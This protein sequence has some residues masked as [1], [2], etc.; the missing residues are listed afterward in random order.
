MPVWGSLRKF[1]AISTWMVTTLEIIHQGITMKRWKNK[2]SESKQRVTKDH[3]EHLLSHAPYAGVFVLVSEIRGAQ[4]VQPDRWQQHLD[5]HENQHGILHA[6]FD[7]MMTTVAFAAVLVQTFQQFHGIQDVQHYL[8][9]IPSEEYKVVRQCFRRRSV[10]E[11][12]VSLAHSWD[13]GPWAQASRALT[14]HNSL[15]F[16]HSDYPVLTV[17]NLTFANRILEG[18]CESGPLLLEC[19]SVTVRDSKKWKRDSTPQFFKLVIFPI[20]QSSIG[21]NWK[22]NQE[23][24]LRGLADANF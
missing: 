21:I 7:L 14:C 22:S 3:A 10:W 17:R 15:R 13:T 8:S 24:F 2:H 19:A 11:F 4:L 1:F 20:Y 18:E 16:S 9:N 12:A 5:G 23:N 6:S